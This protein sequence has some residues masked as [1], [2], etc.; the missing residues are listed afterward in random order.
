M[1]ITPHKGDSRYIRR[2]ASG[3]SALREIVSFHELDA[4]GVV[5]AADG[6]GIAAWLQRADDCRFE[7]PSPYNCGDRPLKRTREIARR[8]ICYDGNEIRSVA[9]RSYPAGALPSGAC[10]YLRHNARSGGII[11]PL[12]GRV[13][14]IVVITFGTR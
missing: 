2:D 7:V 8:W 13:A 11:P 5:L 6:R 1:R 12:L 10:P 9:S 4:G 14:A 3:L